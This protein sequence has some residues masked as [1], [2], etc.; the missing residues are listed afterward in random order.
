VR[1]EGVEEVEK[2]EES[3]VPVLPNRELQRADKQ[4]RS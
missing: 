1:V 3:S 2:V 4:L